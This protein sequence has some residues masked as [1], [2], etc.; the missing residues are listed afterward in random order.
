MLHQVSVSFG[1]LQKPIVKSVKIPT[2][3]KT[4]EYPYNSPFLEI[5]QF[6]IVFLS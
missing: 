6:I 1:E 3:D 5:L 4:T 2:L